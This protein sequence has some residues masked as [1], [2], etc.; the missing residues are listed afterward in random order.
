MKPMIIGIAGP[1]GGGKSTVAKILE[2]RLDCAVFHS[3]SYFKSEL[4]EI[5]SPDDGQVYPDWNH[6]T[7]VRYDE[8][9]ADVRAAA[10]EAAHR[11]IIVEGLLIFYID[12]LRELMDHKIF[13]TARPETCLYRRIVRNTAL[14]GQTPEYI[15]N[16]YLRCARH[17]EAEFCLP[18]EK[19]ADFVID[20]DVSY[21]KDLEKLPF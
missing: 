4:P 2:E 10:E 13:V 5:T 11:Y 20:N 21:E 14:F 17:R 19:Y 1:S 15:G 9:I 18:T 8:L 16:Y 6:P 7:S 3:D 12:E